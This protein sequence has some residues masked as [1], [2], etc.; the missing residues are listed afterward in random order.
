MAVIFE[1]PSLPVLTQTRNREFYLSQRIDIACCGWLFVV[2]FFFLLVSF[3][4]IP[5]LAS[6]GS[7]HFLVPRLELKLFMI[8]LWRSLAHRV[9]APAQICAAS[10]CA[11]CSGSRAAS[12]DELVRNTRFFT[13][14][15]KK[16]K[17]KKLHR[18]QPLP[19]PQNQ[20]YY[21]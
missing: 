15:R 17:K 1:A 7:G 13:K 10:A 5:L 21:I 11:A 16:H 3:P 14:K 20:C 4:W 19:P 8:E 9:L 18:L 6:S 12:V 2:F